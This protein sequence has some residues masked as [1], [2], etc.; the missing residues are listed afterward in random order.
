MK[1]EDKIYIAGHQGLVGSAILKSL[2]KRKFTNIVT[3]THK[4]LDLTNQSAVI[5]FFEE[6]RPSYVLLA[7]A[8]VGGIYANNTYPAEFIYENIMIEANVIHAAYKSGVKRLLFLGSTCIYPREVIQPMREDAILTGV[9]EPTNEPYAIAKIAGIKLCESYNRQYQ[10]DFRSVMPTNLYGANDNFNSVNS[11][12]IPALIS[13]FHEAKVNNAPKVV[14]WGSGKVM[15]DFLYVEDMAEASI[16]VLE[17]DKE[18]YLSNTS[19]MLSHINIGTGMDISIYELAKTIKLVVG[20][21]GEL[22][23]DPSKPDGVKRK[24]VDI[25]RLSAMGWNFSEDLEGGLKKTY[26]WYLNSI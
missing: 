24:L 6:E 17:L 25:S 19:S 12:V 5:N 11:H 1:L 16:F 13:R 7:A 8:K 23:F 9:L 14:V 26:D 20:F 22:K 4:E 10:T 2:R 3:R 21:E 18:T 15:R